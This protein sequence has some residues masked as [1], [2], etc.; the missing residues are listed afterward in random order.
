M[1]CFSESTVPDKIINAWRHCVISNL[2]RT[3]SCFTLD[4]EHS[5]GKQLLGTKMREHCV[6]QHLD[7]ADHQHHSRE[8]VHPSILCKCRT[9]S[10]SP[11]H[12]HVKYRKMAGT[13]CC[14]IKQAQI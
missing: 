13:K 4:S 7:K 2:N 5:L 8:S 3:V 11:A 10:V 12:M 1:P 14:F 9:R 6:L